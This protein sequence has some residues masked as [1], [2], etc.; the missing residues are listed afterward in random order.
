MTYDPRQADN[1]YMGMDALDADEA[2]DAL[3]GSQAKG[4]NEPADNNRAWDQA[5]GAAT[6]GQAADGRTATTS[7]YDGRTMV[8]Q[9]SNERTRRMQDVPQTIRRPAKAPARGV[10]PA[11]PT[12]NPPREPYQ[13]PA[14]TPVPSP[15]RQEY[16]PAPSPV[17]SAIRRATAGPLAFLASIVVWLLGFALRL[18]AI[19]LSLLVVASALLVGSHRASLVSI[20]NMTPLMLPNALFG[21]F[22]YETPFGGVFR[23]DFAIASIILFVLDYVCMRFS[24][25][26]RFRRERRA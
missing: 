8:A 10:A 9:P 7:T 22:V 1:P 5:R 24:T 18:A 4:D 13:R 14:V 12:W 16:Q 2:M 25:S 6:S 17:A 26:L 20:L 15:Q 23:G 21:Q 3:W 11:A 19:A